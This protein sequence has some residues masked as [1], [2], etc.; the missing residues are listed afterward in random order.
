LFNN[1]IQKAAKVL[2]KLN[3]RSFCAKALGQQHLQDTPS[4]VI[5]QYYRLLLLPA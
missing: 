2:G 4:M 5:N 1:V 3:S